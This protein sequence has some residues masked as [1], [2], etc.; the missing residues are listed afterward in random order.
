MGIPTYDDAKMMLELY[1]LRLDPSLKEAQQWFVNDFQPGNWNEVQQRYGPGTKEWQMLTSILGYW[2]IIG[3]LV[4]QN[5]LSED[6]VFDAI[7][8]LDLAW[9][10][11]SAWL[12]GARKGM[13]ID[14]WEN[15]EILV[16]RQAHWK[17]HHRAKRSRT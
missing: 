11:V 8:S 16:E 5:L 14:L 7:E 2:E 6:L 9:D 4:D 13:G 3:A 10:R 1:R 12:P 15:V 17:Q